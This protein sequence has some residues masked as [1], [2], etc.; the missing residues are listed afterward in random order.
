[1]FQLLQREQVLKQQEPPGW[2]IRRHDQPYQRVLRRIYYPTMPGLVQCS[3]VRAVETVI[4]G[5][6]R[7]CL[8]QRLGR[9]EVG[10]FDAAFLKGARHQIH[11]RSEVV[12]GSCT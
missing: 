11:L 9:P 1:M 8:A 4:G 6:I 2:N 5:V 10:A 12:L 3:L 7:G